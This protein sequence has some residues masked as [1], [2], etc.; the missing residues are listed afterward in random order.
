MISPRNAAIEEMKASN[1]HVG[2]RKMSLLAVLLM[3]GQSDVGQGAEDLSG[4]KTMLGGGRRSIE[5]HA[6]QCAGLS[7]TVHTYNLR[8]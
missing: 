4:G 1:I 7:T 2:S 3:W 6:L 8:T 5:K